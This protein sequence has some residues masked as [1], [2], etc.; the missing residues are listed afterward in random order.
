M[1]HKITST[2]GVGVSVAKAHRL[3]TVV[4]S[5]WTST[6]LPNRVIFCLHRKIG[7]Q[8]RH[9]FP[10]LEVE[11]MRDID[12]V[13]RYSSHCKD[14][15]MHTFNAGEVSCVFI[16]SYILIKCKC[17]NLDLI[18]TQLFEF[19]LSHQG[20]PFCKVGWE[21]GGLNVKIVLSLVLNWNIHIWWEHVNTDCLRAHDI[22][23]MNFHKKG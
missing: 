7:I 11:G 15:L 1:L 22:L 12:V 18:T 20:K 13:L 23:P 8:T 6:L 4:V 10:P 5:P 19:R 16:C 21:V 3:W 2:M 14:T 17:F 9:G